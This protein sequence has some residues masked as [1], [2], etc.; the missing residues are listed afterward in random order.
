MSE[1]GEVLEI[2]QQSGVDINADAHAVERDRRQ[3]LER[4][5]GRLAFVAR[6]Q[7]LEKQLADFVSGTDQNL[8]VLGINDQPVAILD[9][10]HGLAD[11]ANHRDVERPGNDRDMRI[12]RALLE[13]DPTQAAAVIVEKLGRAQIAGDE[14]DVF[15]DGNGGTAGLGAGE[16]LKQPVG[17]VL[18]VVDP[19]AQVRIG[20]LA[21]P[22]V[23][24]VAHLLHGGL[25]GQAGVDGL[26][27]PAQ[28]ADVLGDHPVGLEN[29][30]VL[31]ALADGG[32]TQHVVKRAVH[33]GDG[34]AQ[35]VVLD[36]G[37]LG[38][39]PADGE[40][41]LV[42]NGDAEREAAMQARAFQPRRRRRRRFDRNHGCTV[43][44]NAVGHHFGENHGDGLQ[45]L[46]FLVAILSPRR[47]L[48]RQHADDP[49]AAQDRH[50]HQGVIDLLAGLRTIGKARVGSGVGQGQRALLGGDFAD[51]ALPD[52]QPR[53]V[54]GRGAKSLGRE[55]FEHVPG[56]TDVD[57][58]DLGPHV[59]GDDRD[60]PGETSL[61]VP[62][63]RHD[64]ANAGQETAQNQ[65][66][67]A[68]VHHLSRPLSGRG[69]QERRPPGRPV[70]R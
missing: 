41:W 67:L 70:P 37:I 22:R 44:R 61:P 64:V 32:R 31:A 59:L 5:I 39:D 62:L 11:L 48:H 12:G 36:P 54:Y 63:A 6:L 8:G 19:L 47:I 69:R 45:R 49:A 9:P 53:P 50:P 68:V 51:Q 27:D 7:A 10:C 28:P 57:R 38:D 2:D 34:L 3:V 55:Q 16:M 40:P 25:G 18:E 58:A 65:N 66:G 60:D 1:L 17:E 21:H 26:A 4:G 29:V 46:D 52:P 14:D 35:P 20:D 56:A 43:G 24:F 13:H 33:V 23:N 42:K 15:V 30:A